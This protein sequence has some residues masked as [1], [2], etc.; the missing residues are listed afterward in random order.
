MSPSAYLPLAHRLADLAGEAVRPHF[1]APLDPD[2]KADGSPVTL[3][4]RAADVELPGNTGNVSGTVPTLRPGEQYLF[5][6]AVRYNG[7]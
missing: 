7:P 5:N 1:R 2:D 6:F 3:A 4:D